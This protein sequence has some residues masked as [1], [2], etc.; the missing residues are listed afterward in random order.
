MPVYTD[1]IELKSRA[2]AGAT[3]RWWDNNND[4][5][6][7]YSWP[8]S[9]LGVLVGPY[10]C[11]TP[12]LAIVR[13]VYL[14]LPLT[15][16]LNQMEMLLQYQPVGGSWYDIAGLASRNDIAQYLNLQLNFPLAAGDQVRIYVS[17][18]DTVARPV[19]YAWMIEEV[20]L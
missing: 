19:R 4:V 17:S 10:T 7:S 14:R 5:G 12:A 9:T 13:Y 18:T 16:N 6:G 1:A 2:H 8:A 3:V 20:M 15:T 11:P